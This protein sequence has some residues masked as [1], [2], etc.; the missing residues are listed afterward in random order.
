M[1]KRKHI[2]NPLQLLAGKQLLGQKDADEQIMPFLVHLEEVKTGHCTTESI[3]I[4]TVYLR[5]MLS[6]VNNNATKRN[7]TLIRYIT[8][9]GKL[10]LESAQKSFDKGLV[11]RVVLTG[12]AMS[13]ISRAV[14]VFLMIMPNL[15]V[16]M[17]CEAGKHAADMWDRM[18]DDN[19]T[20]RC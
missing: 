13:A 7:D 9:A 1:K 3:R 17:W 2:G 20:A 6:C 14:R 16:Y 11:D 4:I 5:A 8:D 15:Q 18:Q 12:E 10:W 19:N